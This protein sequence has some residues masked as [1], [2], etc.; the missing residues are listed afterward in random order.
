MALRVVDA[1]TVTLVA[2][3]VVAGPVTL[4]V[5]PVVNPDPVK[6]TEPAAPCETPEGLADVTVGRGSI[7]RHPVHTPEPWESVTVIFRTP[8][9]AEELTVALALMVVA[10]TTDTFD[11]VTPVPETLTVA[12][13]MKALPLMT[14][15]MLDAD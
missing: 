12:P 2:L 4:T 10:L 8:G 15:G 5:A 13:V 1:V 14:T 7:V 3:T 9:A 6:V 11:N